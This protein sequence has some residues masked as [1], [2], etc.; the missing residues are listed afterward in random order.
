MEL[1]GVTSSDRGSPGSGRDRVARGGGDRAMTDDDL[2]FP[3]PP[4]EE[5]VAWSDPDAEAA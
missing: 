1:H 2:D 5:D 3:L 4:S